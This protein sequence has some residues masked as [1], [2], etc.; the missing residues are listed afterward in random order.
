MWLHR[1]YDS[2]MNQAIATLGENYN[3]LLASNNFPFVDP[4]KAEED[5]DENEDENGEEVALDSDDDELISY[6]QK[7]DTKAKQLRKLMESINVDDDESLK[8]LIRDIGIKALGEE[9]RDAIELIVSE[10][11]TE[12]PAETKEDL[13]E[14]GEIIDKEEEDVEGEFQTKFEEDQGKELSKEDS[15]LFNEE[16]INDILT[17]MK[18]RKLAP[19]QSFVPLSAAS[20][21]KLMQNKFET[22]SPMVFKKAQVRVAGQPA[23]KDSKKK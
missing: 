23:K 9:S 22:N 10:E 7:D 18:S 6:Y 20:S 13:G 1:K 5:E 3:L 14:Y 16:K 2:L 19:K 8:N 4:D 12:K 15:S 11:I 21:K 17:D